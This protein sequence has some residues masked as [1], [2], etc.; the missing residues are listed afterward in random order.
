MEGP[1]PD[2]RREPQRQRP[3]A[4][5]LDAEE[6]NPSWQVAAGSEPPNGV[7]LATWE[8]EDGKYWRELPDSLWPKLEVAR[9]EGGRIGVGAGKH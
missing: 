1:A 9:K 8:W 7:R 6:C 5:P 2:G 3:D 4:E